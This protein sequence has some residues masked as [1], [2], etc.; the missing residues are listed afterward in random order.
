MLNGKLTY[1]RPLGVN[2]LDILFDWYN[3]N[4]FS[5]WISGNWPLTTLLRQE[6]IEQKLYEEDDHRYGIC[7]LEGTLIG[8]VGFDQFNIPARSARIFIG[9]GLKEFWGQGYGEDALNVFL[10][11]L[12]NQWNLHRIT[13]ETWQNNTRA[14]RCY[15]KLGFCIEGNL[16]EA[17]YIDGQYHDAIVLGLLKRDFT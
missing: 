14:L 4:E 12:F 11:F 13:A 17:Y 1:I 6:E 16:R 2:D 5:Y 9:I 15:Q 8:T 7:N 3:D 10:R